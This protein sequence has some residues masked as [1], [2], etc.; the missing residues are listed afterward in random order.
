[1]ADE[2]SE[3]T[4]EYTVGGRLLTFKMVQ[5]GQII[6]LNRYVESLRRTAA[7]L[8]EAEDLDGMI[9]IGNK[10][11]DATWTTVE[12]QFTN[13]EDLEWVQME[14][15]AGRV[16]ERDLLPLLSNG[17]KRIEPDDDAEPV[18][19]KRPGRKA[20]AKKAAAKKA[21]AKRAAR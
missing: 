1:M 13:P 9:K 5:R 4:F 11:N 14:I 12:S 17:V 20:P 15:I 19:I 3:G 6:M 7:Q 21:P 18:A 2:G 16:D 10:I 8:K